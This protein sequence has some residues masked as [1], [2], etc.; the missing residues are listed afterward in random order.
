[1][2]GIGSFYKSSSGS[3]CVNGKPS[4]N[5]GVGIGVRQWCVMSLWLLNVYVDVCMREMKVRVAEFGPMLKV[6]GLEVTGGGPV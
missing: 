2:E 4:G 3:V 5:F 1:M 6:R